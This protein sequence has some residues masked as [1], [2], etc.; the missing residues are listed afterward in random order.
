MRGKYKDEDYFKIIDTEEKAYFLGLLYAD[1]YIG[2]ANGRSLFCRIGLV[3]N[4][5]YIVEKFVNRIF[6]NTD[7]N[8]YKGKTTKQAFHS[9]S[10]YSNKFCDNLIKMGCFRNKS[11]ILEFPNENQV[12]QHLVRHFVR[13]YFDG[14]GCFSK[15]SGGNLMHFSF[16]SSIPF[17]LKLNEY[18]NH[19]N[20]LTTARQHSKEAPLNYIVRGA[21]IFSLIRFYNLLYSKSTISL[22]RKREKV[23]SFLK[24]R[25]SSFYNKNLSYDGKNITLLKENK[26]SCRFRFNNDEICKHLGIFETKEQA[27]K[28]YNEEAQK[29]I[30]SLTTKEKNIISLIQDL[31]IKL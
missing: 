27:I 16:V 15:S 14:D 18:L 25:I 23:Y 8:I 31:N 1:G 4:D 5:F 21:D 9:V 7:Y 26:W 19:N 6:G 10:I 17:S 11:L 2:C 29:H 30:N 13:G 3:E 22:N 20:I 12:P 28:K 24:E